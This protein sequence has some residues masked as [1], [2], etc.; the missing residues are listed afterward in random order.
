MQWCSWTSWLT[1]LP[2]GHWCYCG[3]SSTRESSV[4][5]QFSCQA[6]L[7][8]ICW[9]FA[10]AEVGR[11]TALNMIVNISSVLVLLIGVMGNSTPACHAGVGKSTLLLQVAAMLGSDTSAGPVSLPEAEVSAAEEDGIEEDEGDALDD[12]DEH[13]LADDDVQDADDMEPLAAAGEA[14]LYVSAEESV[15]QVSQNGLGSPL[16]CLCCQAYEL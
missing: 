10:V 5:L 8:L 6:E 13:G 1:S 9:S 2:W 15:E 12:E 3:D 4:F 11:G 7:E 14:V 16:F